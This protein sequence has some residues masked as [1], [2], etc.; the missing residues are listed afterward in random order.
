[1][2]FIWLTIACNTPETVEVPPIPALK[3]PTAN[4]ASSGDAS[5]PTNMSTGSSPA[6]TNVRTTPFFSEVMQIPLKVAKFRGEWIELYNP[7]DAIIDLSTYSVHSKGDKGISFTAEHSIQPKSAFL[8]AVRK[9]PSGNGGL[10][11]IDFLYNH[12]VLKITA[13]DWIELRKGTEVADR[14]EITRTEVKKGYSLQRSDNGTLCHA[15]QTYGD[16]DYGSP[17]AISTCPVSSDSTDTK[18]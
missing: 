8:M 4:N 5:T 18:P 14:W 16:G 12:D 15:T 13:T 7:T 11:T 6:K 2:L 3:E 10:P 1:M 9:S 17:K